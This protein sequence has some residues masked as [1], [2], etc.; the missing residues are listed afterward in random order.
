[1]QFL[2]TFIYLNFWAFLLDIIV[3]LSGVVIV[4]CPL[5][6][7]FKILPGLG[8]LF[9]LLKAVELHAT[10]G[11]KYRARIV[12]LARNRKSF[13]E[14]SFEQY[15]VAPCGR[16]IVR[17]VLISLNRKSEFELLKR[18]YY[19]GFFSSDNKSSLVIIPNPNKKE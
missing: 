14:D 4:Y 18:K 8:V 11:R 15:M 9:I 17:D 2:R 5:T 19:K 6:F 3:V 7:Y 10:V 1:M 16:M 13:R 12:L